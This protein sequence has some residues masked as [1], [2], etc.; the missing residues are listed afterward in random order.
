MAEVQR[1][2]SG[3][4]LRRRGFIAGEVLAGAILVS[5]AVTGV[6]WLSSVS[7]GN[8]FSG[9]DQ[10]ARPHTTTSAPVKV[11]PGELRINCGSSGERKVEDFQD[12]VFVAGGVATHF[13]FHEGLGS[14]GLAA[15][16]IQGARVKQGGDYRD[17]EH[18]TGAVHLVQKETGAWVIADESGSILHPTLTWRSG[19]Q[20]P[21]KGLGY[22]AAHITASTSTTS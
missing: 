8:P 13:T 2:S 20:N 9:P 17:K 11:A 14:S 6:K 21:P 12:V 7:V 10:E 16:D 5:L 3:E 4:T 1:G 18:W 15:N 22:E 19:C